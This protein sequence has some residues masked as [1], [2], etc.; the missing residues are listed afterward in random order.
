[1]SGKKVIEF[2]FDFASTYSYLS[3]MRIDALASGAGFQVHWK[4]FLLG[5]IF[6]SQGWKNSPFNIYP[7]KG[8]YMWRDME[9]ICAGR[10]L[11]LVHPDPFPQNSLYAARLALAAQNE[12]WASDLCKAIFEAEFARGEN[13]ADRGVLIG[14]LKGLGEDASHWAERMG[15]DDVKQALKNQVDEATRRGIF[16]AP[17]FFVDGELYWGDDRLDQALGLRA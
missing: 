17:S 12:P 5:P 11:Q 9:R 7:V 4:P 3:A 13:I 1:M 8:A 10:N 16:G 6:A 14:V 15:E 2:W